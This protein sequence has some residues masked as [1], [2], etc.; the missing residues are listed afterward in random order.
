MDV[1]WFRQYLVGASGEV[2]VVCRV[3]R[4]KKW[5]AALIIVSALQNYVFKG[6]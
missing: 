5:M 2:T 6:A 3:N 4:Q 1:E